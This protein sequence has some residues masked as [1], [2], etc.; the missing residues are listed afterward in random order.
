M[1]PTLP[2]LSLAPL[3]CAGGELFDRIVNKAHY[4]EAEA[5]TTVRQVA[6][7]LEFLHARGIVHRDLKPECV[8]RAPTMLLARARA[9][10][11]FLALPI[12]A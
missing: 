1:P 5:A 4:S 6:S 12:C 8:V 2:P 9:R 3:L 11:S 10:G 7:A